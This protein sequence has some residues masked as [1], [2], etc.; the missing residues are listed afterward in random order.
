MAADGEEE[1]DDEEWDRLMKEHE[2]LQAENDALKVEISQNAV[3]FDYDEEVVEFEPTAEEEAAKLQAQIEALR[4]EGE[5]LQN[6]VYL[7]EELQGLQ[8]TNITLREATKQL[9]KENST[10]QATSG[11]AVGSRPG[12]NAFRK[13]DEVP[14]DAL[15]RRVRDLIVSQGRGNQDVLSTCSKRQRQEIVAAMMKSGLFDPLTAT[16]ATAVTTQG[17]PVSKK[18]GKVTQAKVGATAK[19]TAPVDR[20]AALSPV[21]VGPGKEVADAI[22]RGDSKALNSVIS[23]KEQQKE[24]ISN[25][26]KTGLFC[27][28]PGTL[29]ATADDERQMEF[30]QERNMPPPEKFCR[31]IRDD[32][33]KK[34]LTRGQQQLEPNVI[35]TTGDMASG[36]L[37][38]GVMDTPGPERRSAQREALKDKLQGLRQ[39]EKL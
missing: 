27:P 36:V 23:D 17:P 32:E 37:P 15:D 16:G 22:R 14:L 24:L 28:P 10:L 30:G 25:M 34:M 1:M 21:A 38:R 26:L 5:A 31:D 11:P 18:A 9:E 39:K 20:Q 8:R 33:M 35:K 29:H 7:G 2:A 3:S 12:A 19:R 4:R 6:V 13:G